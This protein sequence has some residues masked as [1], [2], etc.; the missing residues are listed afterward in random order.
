MSTVPFEIALAFLQSRRSFKPRLLSEPGPSSDEIERFVAAALTA[1]DHGQLRPFRL[2]HIE[3][4]SY[5]RLAD[6]YEAA[7]R[8]IAPDVGPDEVRIVRA[9][10]A[11]SPCVLAFIATL[12]PAHELIP[13]H[14][15]LFAVGAALQNFLLAAHAA[16]YGASLLSGKRVATTALRTA[17]DLAPDEQLVGFIS[18]GTP[19]GAPKPRPPAH[20][21]DHLGRW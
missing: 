14:E 13:V 17:L 6:A 1:P 20:P 18:I 21:R 7:A 12:A 16:G 15:Q 11:D 3:P 8:E 19:Q 4:Q 9:K 10:A 5:P 2:L